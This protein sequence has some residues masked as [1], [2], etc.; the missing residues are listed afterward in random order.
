M[1]V[2]I[3]NRTSTITWAGNAVQTEINKTYKGNRGTADITATAHH[4]LT[5]REEHHH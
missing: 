5:R 3:V 4:F 1:G 2:G